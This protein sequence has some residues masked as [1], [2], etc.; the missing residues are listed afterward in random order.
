MSRS[1]VPA[2]ALR[3]LPNLLSAARIG[4]APLLVWLAADRAWRVRELPAEHAAMVSAP[5]ALAALL[6][7]LAEPPRRA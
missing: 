2:P 7:E 1:P 5:D 3:H 6:D 4:C